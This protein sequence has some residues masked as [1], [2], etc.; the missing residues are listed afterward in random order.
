[1]PC[2]SGRFAVAALALGTAGL[3][4]ATAQRPD[5]WKSTARYELEYRVQLRDVGRAPDAVALWVPYPAETR[6]QKI[7]G[8]H[9]EIESALG[10]GTTVS[11]VFPL[12]DG[13]VAAVAAP[14]AQPVSLTPLRLLL[15]DDDPLVLQSLRATLEVD[16]HNVVTASGGQ[17]GID[18]FNAAHGRGEKLVLSAEFT[19]LRRL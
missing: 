16:G 3:A 6:D 2:W 1:M 13:A 17:A 14:N 7:L 18:A 9:V 19:D 15:V 5:L 8:A 12:P 4:S 11:I 10:K